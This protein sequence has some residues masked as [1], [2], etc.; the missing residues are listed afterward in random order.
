MNKLNQGL[1]A[2]A[3]LASTVGPALARELPGPDEYAYSFPLQIQGDSEFFALDIPVGVYRSVSDPALRDAGVY[4][5]GGQPVPRLF[6][7]PAEDDED[8]EEAV[9]LGLMP[10]HGDEAERPDQLRL[11][12]QQADTGITLELDAGDAAEKE[13]ASPLKAYVVDARDLEHDIVALAFRWP[14][15]PQGFIGRV[16]VEQSEDLQTWRR[17][18]AASLADLE[19]GETRIEQNRVELSG[20]VS[21]YLRINWR[22]MPAGW[23]LEAVS[24][25]YTSQGAPVARDELILDSSRPGDTDREFIFDAG[26]FPPVDRVNVILPDDNVVIRAGIFYRR[27]GEDRWRQAHNGIFYN[28]SRQGNALQSLP[29]AVPA[30][31]AGQWK[32]RVDSGVTADP[33]RLQLGWRPDR[34]VFLAQGSPP[35]ELVAG[36]A[37]DRLEQFPQDKLLGD[38]SIF[39]VLRESSQAGGASIGTREVRAGPDQ[40]KVAATQTWRVV[41]LWAGLVGAI[42]LVG[43]LVYSLM[44]E[45]RG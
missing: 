8:I 5:A 29:A 33:V 13:G 24:G 45:M 15:Q 6:E 1:L 40:L 30:A 14:E 35:F 36:R 38:R 22:N 9:N 26:G 42:A 28:V 18:G 25:I 44:R 3:W 23:S 34:L 2:A 20:K 16:M 21:G 17:L 43:W 31:R 12:L 32:I 11:L 19:Y 7:R 4:N 37:Q 41:L 27:D 39:G 10:L